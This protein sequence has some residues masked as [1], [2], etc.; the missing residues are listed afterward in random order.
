MK[1]TILKKTY[2]WKWGGARYA[3]TIFME[4]LEAISY[5]RVQLVMYR[6]FVMRN[7]KSLRLVGEVEN[8]KNGTVRTI[9]EGPKEKLIALAEKLKKGPLLARVEKVEV[10]YVPA[11]HTFTT[12][13]IRYE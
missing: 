4:R 6:D 13:E 5:G 7:A 10:D 3:K 9:A 1:L 11:T 8:L 12:F 2:F